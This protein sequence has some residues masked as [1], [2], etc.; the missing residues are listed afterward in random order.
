M[1]NPANLVSQ[2]VAQGAGY[3]PARPVTYNDQPMLTFL[4]PRGAP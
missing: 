1:I 2:K 4:R 3:R